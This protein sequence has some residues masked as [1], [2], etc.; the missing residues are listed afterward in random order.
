MHICYTM[1]ASLHFT[2]T[3]YAPSRIGAN[4]DA[5][6]EIPS[7]PDNFLNAI[8]AHRILPSFWT[9][10]KATLHWKWIEKGGKQRTVIGVIIQSTRAGKSRNTTY[11]IL[12][13]Q[14]LKLFNCLFKAFLLRLQIR[15]F[16][17]LHLH[18]RITHLL[19]LSRIIQNLSLFL[20]SNINLGELLVSFL[21]FAVEVYTADYM[22]EDRGCG[23]YGEDDT[24]WGSTVGR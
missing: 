6:P 24:S 7:T 13:L 15:Q 19:Y 22:E 23:R 10:P 4:M 11:L 1:P 5:F 20:K 17:F 2:R 9:L 3:E 12:Q 14:L 21:D 8:L 16:I 18:Q